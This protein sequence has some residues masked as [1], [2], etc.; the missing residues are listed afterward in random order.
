MASYFKTL[1]RFE[2][3]YLN[4]M[5]K[6]YDKSLQK[7]F[8]TGL[9]DADSRGEYSWAMAGGAKQA[10]I[11]S[12]WNFLEPGKRFMKGWQCFRAE[13]ARRPLA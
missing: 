6:N 2:Q 9:R 1:C 4:D 10:V 11:F 12:N 5:M 8:W 7:Y 13:L 3:E